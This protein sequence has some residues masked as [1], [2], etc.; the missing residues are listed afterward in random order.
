MT[1]TTP[2]PPAV[3]VAR[4]A[5]AY[6]DHEVLR[7]VD[8]EVPA[9]TVYALLGPNGAGKTT[10]VRILSTLL[11]A[12]AGD[13]RVGGHDVRQDPDGVRSSI[14][15]TGQFSAVDELLTGR[16]NLR[17][18]ADLG[19]LDRDRATEVVDELLR[20]FDLVDAADRRA[21]SYSGGMK[22]RLDLAMTLVHGPRL[23][24]LDEPTAGLDP[25]S[26]RELWQIVRELVAGGVTVF[27]TTQY[28]DEA[29]QLAD[30]IGV[31]HGGRLVAEGTSAQL[32]RLVPGGQVELQV[33]DAAALDRLAERIP[34]GVAD[35]ETLTLAVPSDGRPAAVRRLLEAVPEDAVTA[36]AL[37]TPDLDDVF[38][39]LT[40]PTTGDAERAE[41][42]A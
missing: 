6:G 2:T 37:R 36:I 8:L 7:G 22:R 9:G 12:D 14:G 4:L 5:K 11:P 19:H 18:M 39:A 17:M 32:K 42:A 30:R 16:E 35:A 34:Q 15:V 38:L 1:T 28:L 23:I 21:A 25:R 3:S 27:L 10:M 31:L 33:A 29:D 41:V 26:R 24:F 20:R 13:A 40:R